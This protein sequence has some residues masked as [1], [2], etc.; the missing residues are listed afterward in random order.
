MTF[1]QQYW[2]ESK[3][4]HLVWDELIMYAKV[5]WAMYIKIN[6]FLVK[7][8]LRDLRDLGKDKCAL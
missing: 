2:H 7:L 6:A 8:C 3:V 5:A 4:K 1:N